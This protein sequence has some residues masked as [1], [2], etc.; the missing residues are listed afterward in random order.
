M[1]VVLV[2]IVRA[3]VATLV[4]SAK[5]MDNGPATH[6]RLILVDEPWLAAW[7]GRI[8]QP[9]IKW[10]LCVAMDAGDPGGLQVKIGYRPLGRTQPS[11]LTTAS[12]ICRVL[13]RV[14]PSL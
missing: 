14:V 5:S 13:T 11:A 12:P 2:G 3:P 7:S 9:K 4:V 8:C 10:S 6:M 1:V